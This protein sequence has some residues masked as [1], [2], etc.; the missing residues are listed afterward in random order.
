M[1][2]AG[3]VDVTPIIT[4]RFDLDRAVEALEKATLREDGKI[5][6]KP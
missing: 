5:T 1:M 2:A 4:S 6:I 3:L